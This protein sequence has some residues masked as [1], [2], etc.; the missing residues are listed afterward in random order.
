MYETLGDFLSFFFFG[1]LS[2]PMFAAAA[3][4]RSKAGAHHK[5]AGLRGRL[6]A[7]RRAR[8]GGIV[9]RPSD[10]LF[11]FHSP[12]LVLVLIHFILFQ[13][14]FEFAYFFWTLVRLPKTPYRTDLAPHS[15]SINR[16]TVGDA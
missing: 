11:W 8:G 2:F 9:V 5:Q 15:R 6:E 16:F 13:N 14:A 4:D 10:E 1:L 7:R 3:S 12:R